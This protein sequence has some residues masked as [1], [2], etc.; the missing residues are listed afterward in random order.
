[1]KFSYQIFALLLMTVTGCA[2]IVSS[3]DESTSD[4][5]AGAV[6]L[7]RTDG[8]DPDALVIHLGGDSGTPDVMTE[9]DSGV[10]EDITSP[11][12][13]GTHERLR[14]IT[15]YAAPRTYLRGER[16]QLVISFGVQAF[17]AIRFTENALLFSFDQFRSAACAV[18]RDGHSN[19]ES[20]ALRNRETGTIVLGPLNIV[21]LGA[22]TTSRLSEF[23]HTG[24][25]DSYDQPADTTVHYELITTFRW[26]DPG[27]PFLNERFQATIGNVKTQTFFSRDAIVLVNEGRLVQPEE[28]GNNRIMVGNVMTV[29]GPSYDTRT[30]SS[31]RGEFWFCESRFESLPASE[32]NGYGTCCTNGR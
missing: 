21:D 19:Y 22:A 31:E 30:V 13:G 14:V 18:G 32:R 28:I 24:A 25:T 4:D 6:T 3:T 8:S 2:Q 29:G 23:L 10:D 5:D 17:D 12:D 7:L 26:S 27:C 15:E 1:M 20:I 11:V 16:N 9:S